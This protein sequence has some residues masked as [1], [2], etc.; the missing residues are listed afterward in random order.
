MK[1]TIVDCSKAIDHPD[2]VREVEIDAEEEAKLLEEA[3]LVV[4]KE[5][6]PTIEDRLAAIEAALAVK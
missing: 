5:Q 2:R 3:S 1:K 4:S 6:A